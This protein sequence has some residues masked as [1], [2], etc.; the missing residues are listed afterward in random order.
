[1]IQLDFRGQRRMK[2]PTS[3]PSVLRNPT[4]PKN[5]QP[6]ANPQLWSLVKTFRTK[7]FAPC[8]CWFAS[9]RW[10]CCFQ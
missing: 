9:T 6:L 5:L 3:T 10:Q 7:K 1:M 4:P 8:T 2:K